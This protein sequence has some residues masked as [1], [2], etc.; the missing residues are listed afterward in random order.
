MKE[1]VK[2]M[3]VVD[4]DLFVHHNERPT[5]NVKTTEPREDDQYPDCVWP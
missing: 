2:F 3:P 4:V 5:K 1:T